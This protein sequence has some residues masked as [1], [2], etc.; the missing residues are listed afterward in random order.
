MNKTLMQALNRSSVLS[1]PLAASFGITPE[2]SQWLPIRD[3]GDEEPVDNTI[4][5]D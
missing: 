5:V 4:I 1:R 3:D 2:T